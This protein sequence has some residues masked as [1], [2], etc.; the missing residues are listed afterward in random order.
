MYFLL[1]TV[2]LLQLLPLH[3]RIVFFR[4]TTEL[5]KNQPYPNMAGC[6]DGVLLLGCIAQR[7]D[8]T[9]EVLVVL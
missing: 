6:N 5:L 1:R 2:I 7:L 4:G 8:L 3:F 9:Q